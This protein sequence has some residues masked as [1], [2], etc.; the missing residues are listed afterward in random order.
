MEI[1]LI[2]DPSG[3]RAVHRFN[4][5]PVL[6]GTLKRPVHDV[7]GHASEL[8]LAHAQPDRVGEVGLQAKRPPIVDV[9]PT[10]IVWV[11]FGELDAEDFGQFSLPG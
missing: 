11:P 5:R 7:A 8:Q 3:E 1:G 10:V 2:D 9:H 6:R 4:R